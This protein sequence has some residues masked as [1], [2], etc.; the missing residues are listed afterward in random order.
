[1]EPHE[2]VTVGTYPDYIQANLARLRLEADGI[3]ALIE[4]DY[5]TTIDPLL[6]CALGGVKLS[7]PEDDLQVAFDIL[8]AHAQAVAEVPAYCPRC[9]SSDVSRGKHFAFLAVLFFS[10]PF[11]PA[12]RWVRCQACKHAWREIP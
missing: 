7:V 5:L 2:L 3:A 6:M 10:F 9:N 11:G 4:D 1:M 12:R 8:R